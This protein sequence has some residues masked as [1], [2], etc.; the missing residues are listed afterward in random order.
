MLKN[1]QCWS[2]EKANKWYQDNGCIAGVNYVPA[3]ADNTT[4]FWQSSTFNCEQ[5]ENELKMAVRFGYNAIR[6]FLQFLLWK[7][8][9]DEFIENFKKFLAILEKLNL[10]VV[11]VFFDDCAF[12]EEQPYVGK[13]KEPIPFIPNSRWT[14]CPGDEY[15]Y[16]LEKYAELSQYVMEMIGLF[17][18]YDQIL[19]WDMYNEP[20]NFAK[21][22]K[23]L[24]LLEKSFEWA[25]S[26]D[27][28]KPLTACSWA[29]EF[30]DDQEMNFVDSRANE[31]SDIITFHLYANA[32]KTEKVIKYLQKYGYPIVCT[33]C[34]AR[35]LGSRFE[36]I[37]PVFKRN[38][39]GFFSWGLVNGRTQTHYPWG[40]SSEKGEPAMWFH[41]V[42]RGD[43]T[44]Y[45]S[46]ESE[47]VKKFICKET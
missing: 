5:I 26:A 23:S 12:G 30:I 8:E 47:L 6:V 34:I 15:Y 2:N 25:R 43:G 7:E 37:L 29:R 32:E 3:Y 27:A 1:M 38:R 14:S 31:L 42:I 36:N 33:E 45:N 44:F 39:V 4:E 20:G 19:M 10:K 13:Q 17:D 28:K 24:Y 21:G 40:W 18:H 46:E 9:H 22:A 35:H 16:N 41:D 11:P